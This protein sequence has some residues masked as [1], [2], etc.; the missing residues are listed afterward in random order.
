MMTPNEKTQ[1]KDN[2]SGKELPNT[3]ARFRPIFSPDSA[4]KII[5]LREETQ[6]TLP[7]FDKLKKV[8]NEKKALLLAFIAPAVS[9]RVSPV[10]EKRAI[11]DIWEELG[12]GAAISKILKDK[13]IGNLF[14]LIDS[15]G[16][17]VDSSYKVALAL[18]KNFRDITVFIPRLAAS[19][20]TF[21]AMVG[22]KIVMSDMAHLTPIDVQVSYKGERVS[23]NTIEQAITRLEKYFEK[24]LPAEAPYPYRAMTEKLD[25]ILREDWG[26]YTED[27]WKYAYEILKLAGYKKEDIIKIA[28]SF[29]LSSGSHTFVVNKKRA[30]SY[31]LK[32][33]DE[34]EDLKILDFMSEWLRIY[35]PQTGAKHFIRYILPN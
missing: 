10:E 18:R 32:I 28:A 33:S 6:K 12:I 23:A 30:E 31:G 21:V 9:E 8:A 22:N 2:S 4:A 26:A 11:I 24:K 13:E 20:G 29:I 3:R 14:L 17:R 16:G 15:P 1:N 27:I 5:D 7:C 19:G 34:E 25:P 35:F